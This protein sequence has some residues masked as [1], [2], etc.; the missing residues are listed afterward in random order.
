MTLDTVFI[1]LGVKL[2]LFALWCVVIWLVSIRLGYKFIG[3]KLQIPVVIRL[4][5]FVL[6]FLLACT[7]SITLV[8][9]NEIA[10]G[11]YLIPMIEITARTIISGLSIGQLFGGSKIHLDRKKTSGQGEGDEEESEDS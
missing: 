11:K 8:S 9:L 10:K 3:K 7:Y 2:V 1:N 5:I 4:L 6:V